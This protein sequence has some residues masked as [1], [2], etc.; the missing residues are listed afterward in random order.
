MTSTGNTDKF[1][2]KATDKRPICLLYILA[3]KIMVLELA[4]ETVQLFSQWFRF[5]SAQI[6]LPSRSEA[7]PGQS[8]HVL[9]Y[10]LG[11]MKID[12]GL[13]G[14]SFITI[15]SLLLS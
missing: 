6:Q 12:F 4:G 11:E 10:T 3:W 13:M 15:P 14:A 9:C 7:T 2:S 1:I 5:M 8:C